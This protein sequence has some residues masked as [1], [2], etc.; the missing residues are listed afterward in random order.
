MIAVYQRPCSAMMIADAVLRAVS[1]GHPRQFRAGP[2]LAA[3]V[4]TAIKTAREKFL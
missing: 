2:V 4:P 3:I 1:L